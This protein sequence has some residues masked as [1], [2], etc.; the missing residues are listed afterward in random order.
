MT[1]GSGD[2]WVQGDQKANVL[3]AGDGNNK[4]YG[5]AGHDV[6]IGGSGNDQM[7]GGDG[8]DTVKFEG[9][10][11]YKADLKLGWQNTGQG[12]DFLSGFENIT[13]GDGNDILK[14]KGG[15][16]ILDGGA[17]NDILNGRSGADVLIGGEG[18][19]TLL[20]GTG[21]DVFRFY[22]SEGLSTDTIKDFGAGDSVELVDDTGE[23]AVTAQIT[24]GVNGSTVTW[25]E[26]TIVFEG[27]YINYDDI[28]PIS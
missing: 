20:G 14:G 22:R 11:S 12:T 8:I 23:S 9:S 15:T 24:D 26:L 28:N 25:D 21:A 3:S 27:A 18:N 4:I 6:L 19:D 7:L 17:G 10:G 16:N 5:L 13:M 2:D 1:T